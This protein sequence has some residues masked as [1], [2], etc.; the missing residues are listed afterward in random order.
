MSRYDSLEKY[1]ADDE[2]QQQEFAAARQRREREERREQRRATEISAS[3]EIARLRL[4]LEGRLTAIERKHEELSENLV[5]IS[6]ATAE[7]VEVLGDQRCDL[8]RDQRAELHDLRIEV[9]K[10][11][12]VT[13]EMQKADSTFR[14]AR[15][16][17]AEPEELPNPLSARRVN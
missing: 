9:A 15:E 16:K 8:S 5:D 10:L 4:E 2:K 11:T 12:S 3:N 13:M 6:R 17:T 14:F 7:A 1:R